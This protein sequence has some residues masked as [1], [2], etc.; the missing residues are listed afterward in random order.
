MAIRSLV[1]SLLFAAIFLRGGRLHLIT[2]ERAAL[3]AGAG[4]STA[5][6]F[7]RMLPELSDAGRVF[8]TAS[9]GRDLPAPELRVYASALVGFLL[10]YGLQNLVVWSHAHGAQQRAGRVGLRP[11]MLLHIGGFA[12]YAS[13]VSYLLVRGITEEPPRMAL[14][15]VAM[16]LHF[17]GVNRSLRCEHGAAYDRVGRYILAGAVLAGWGAG[18]L[19]QFPQPVVITGLGFVS[20]GVVMNS[21]VM[22]LP[23]DQ[24]G[25]FWPF[26][27]GALSYAGLLALVR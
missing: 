11:I 24:E 27:G 25:H 6:V 21:M 14:Y 26:F 10:F 3:S 2:S 23:G 20:G 1:A 19:M 12:M 9:A 7:V 5:Y 16:G 15:A 8:V 22:E 17:L 13:L 4:V 18:M